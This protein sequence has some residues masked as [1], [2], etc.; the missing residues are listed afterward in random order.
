MFISNLTHMLKPL[1]AYPFPTTAMLSLMSATQNLWIAPP[2][3]SAPPLSASLIP[4]VGA[5]WRPTT[6]SP[7]PHS[8]VSHST[9][10]NC[11][12]TAAVPSSPIW[13]ISNLTK[14]ST[15]CPMS[16]RHQH[17]IG[18]SGLLVDTLTTSSHLLACTM[19][20][21]SVRGEVPPLANTRPDVTAAPMRALL[22]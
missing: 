3:M 22:G 14:G 2:P 7:V 11:P 4:L 5:N 17:V 15:M 6:P 10:L 8:M 19:T 20:L 9:T 1:M 21:R 16:R 13:T 18:T 12:S